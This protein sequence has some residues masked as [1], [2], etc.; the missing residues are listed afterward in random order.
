[1]TNWER[2]QRFES[3]QRIAGIDHDTMIKVITARYL[4]NYQVHVSSL[5]IKKEFLSAAR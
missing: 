1:M 4:G 2:A 3:L 5:T